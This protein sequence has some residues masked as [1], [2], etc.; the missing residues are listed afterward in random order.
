MY[1]SGFTAYID[2][3]SIMAAGKHALEVMSGFQRYIKSRDLAVIERYSLE[4]LRHADESLGDRDVNADFRIA[5][6]NRIQD[7]QN[8][9]EKNY[10]SWVRVV[11][12]R[13]AFVAGVLATPLAGRLA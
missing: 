3:G 11:G 1:Q 2:L 6:R 5:L 8:K 12:Y 7:I 9:D 4:D 10:Q 13:V